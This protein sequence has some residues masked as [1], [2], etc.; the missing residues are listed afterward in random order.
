LPGSEDASDASRSADGQE[1]LRSRLRRYLKD[2]PRPLRLFIYENREVIPRVFVVD[3]TRLFAKREQL[4]SAL[5]EASREE[6]ASTAFLLRDEANGVGLGKT[7]G[8]KASV[9]VK[10]IEAEQ[11]VVS[12]RLDRPGILVVTQNYTPYWK[13]RVDGVDSQVIPVDHTFQGVSLEPGRHEVEL[14]YRP[15]YAFY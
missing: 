7:S 1:R 6:L 5:A 13:A 15:P 14:T 3:H 4:L 12:V 9:Q 8:G 10:V 11:V 2:G